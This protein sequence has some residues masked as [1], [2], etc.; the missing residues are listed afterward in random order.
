MA[1][2]SSFR[3]LVH[4]IDGIVWEADARSFEFIYVSPQTEELLGYTPGEWTSKPTFWQDHIHPDDR[5]WAVQYCHQETLKGRPHRFEYRIQHADGHY[6][7]MRDLVTVVRQGSDPVKLRGVMFDISREKEL[8][9]E[10]DLAYDKLKQRVIEQECV[11]R[12]S[13]LDEWNLTVP[14][15][16]E[17]S[18][19]IIP[20]GFRYS[21]VT[22]VE[23]SFESERFATPGY[24]PAEPGLESTINLEGRAGLAIRVVCREERPEWDIGPFMHEE[25]TMLDTIVRHLS[26]KVEEILSRDELRRQRVL[27]QE[28]LKEKETLL[29]EVHHRVK[30]NLAV[31]SG[32]MLLQAEESDHE[33]V[34]ERLIDSVA[35]VKT[36]AAIHE[37]LYQSENFSKLDFNSHITSLVESIIETVQ[38]KTRI[39]LDS[40]SDPLEMTISNAIPASLIVNEVTT[41]I[42][43]HGFSG[44]REG[45]IR[46]RVQVE[47]K[48]KKS[49]VTLIMEDNGIGLPENFDQEDYTSLG[50]NLIRVLSKQ[51]DADYTYENLSEGVRFTLRFTVVPA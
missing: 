23:I 10:R 45:K 9:E 47:E 18:L 25:K 1:D 44:R 7:W 42:L 4:S 40:H 50:M 41:N 28:S 13:S 36:M 11:Y 48:E 30:N 6:I 22:D 3:S 14:E 43:K 35:R 24:M 8:E 15:L 29:A 38:P 16:L 39:E 5:E 32:M 12:I 31:V 21:D 37:Q 26:L 46:I 20:G 17:E 49:V 34:A 27:L 19:E 33:E 51:L 2:S